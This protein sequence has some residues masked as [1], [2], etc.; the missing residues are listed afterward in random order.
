MLK[1]AT[2]HLSKVKINHK[3]IEIVFIFVHLHTRKIVFCVT[4]VLAENINRDQFAPT[5]ALFSI[6]K[7]TFGV[8]TKKKNYD[9]KICTATYFIVLLNMVS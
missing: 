6:V 9:I 8:T 4:M 2:E 5:W 3:T 7:I 1:I